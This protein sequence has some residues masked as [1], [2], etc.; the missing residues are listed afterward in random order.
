MPEAPH[1][2]RRF[3]SGMAEF[4]FQT[5]LGVADPPLIDYISDL[6]IRFINSNSIYRIRNVTGQRLY[7]VAQMMMEAEERIGD[8]KRE[9]HRHVGD[10][11]LFWTGVY[12]E[13]LKKMRSTGSQDELVDYKEQGKR[14]YLIA[15]QI[16][17]D[18]Q[19]ASSDVLNRLS[20]QYDLCAYGLRE[21]RRQWEND[22]DGG[23]KPF[24]IG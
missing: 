5:H 20:H 2:L 11:T 19:N 1:T 10:F 13:A 12:P 17:T 22:G 18:D 24:L 15:S 3:F 21:V 6:L 8:A 9:V 7:E 14:A 23:I 4:T 16:Q